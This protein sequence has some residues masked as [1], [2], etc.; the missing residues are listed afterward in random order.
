M[1]RASAC[2]SAAGRVMCGVLV[3]GENDVVMFAPVRVMSSR[4]GSRV[5]RCTTSCR[6]MGAS[7]VKGSIWS[8]R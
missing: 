6:V 4:A 8:A 2:T 5:A 3:S 1:V 7:G